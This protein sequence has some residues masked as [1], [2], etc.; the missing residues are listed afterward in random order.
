MN[1]NVSMPMTSAPKPAASHAARGTAGHDAANADAAGE[2]GQ[3][4][5]GHRFDQAL[6]QQAA[7]P[8]A[9]TAVPLAVP[10]KAALPQGES[11]LPPAEQDGDASTDPAERGGN[12]LAA[13]VLALLG[14]G[15]AVPAN[16]VAP[17][18]KQQGL[19][20]DAGKGGGQHGASALMALAA[21]G[22]ATADA[23]APAGIADASTL[24]AAATQAVAPDTH[25]SEQ[26]ASLDALAAPMSPQTPGTNVAPAA[27]A[28]QLSTLI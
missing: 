2:A 17:G 7:T 4:G 13:A 10:P 18:G 3:G 21:Q 15:T 1:A 12:A 26:P 16:A 20:L 11:V 5:F 28:P 9:G 23:A 24:I 19:S 22:A 8:V 27:H 6:K 14:Q 25:K